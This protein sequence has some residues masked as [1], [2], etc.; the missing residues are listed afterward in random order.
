MSLSISSKTP[1]RMPVSP[2]Q[3][4]LMIQLDGS[5]KYGYEMLKTLKDE[6]DGVW[7]PK[8]G[9]VYPALKSLARKGFV[10]TEERDGTEYYHITEKGRKL[11]P[12]LEKHFA[13]SLG[14][15]VNYLA[16]LFKWMSKE[17]KQ[18]ALRIMS[19]IVDKDEDMT[20]KML[21][22][23]HSNLDADVKKSFL[24]KVREMTEHRLELVDKLLEETQ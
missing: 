24:N 5:P 9:T 16:V 15:T 22:L 20:H 2:L 8:T 10:E 19:I 23:F 18:G 13:D 1:V 11:F 17:M 6:F 4:L 7:E 12:E 14:F 3:V 21:Y